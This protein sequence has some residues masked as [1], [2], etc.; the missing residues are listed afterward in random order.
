MFARRE[1]GV[2]FDMPGV[3]RQAV[4]WMGREGVFSLLLSGRSGTFNYKQPTRTSL[5]VIISIQDI[6]LNVSLF[7]FHSPVFSLW[8]SLVAFSKFFKGRFSKFCVASTSWDTGRLS[9]YCTHTECPGSACLHVAVLSVIQTIPLQTRYFS[10][11]SRLRDS[12]DNSK[13]RSVLLL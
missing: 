2:Y 10:H 7:F 5:V 3:N 4:C 11:A 12:S 13:L 1:G 8:F 6:P 9:I